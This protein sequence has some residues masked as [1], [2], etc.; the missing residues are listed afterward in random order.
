MADDWKDQLPLKVIN[1]LVY[2]LFLGSNISTIFVPTDI[3]THYKDTYITPSHGH[4]SFGLHFLIFPLKSY[5]QLDSGKRVII[6]GISWRFPLLGVFNAVFVNLWASNHH[7]LSFIFAILVSS[8]VSH[9]YY[10]VKKFHTPSNLYDELLVHLPFSLYHGWTTVLVVLTAFES[11]GA[12]ASKVA[13]SPATKAW[14][15]VALLFLESTGA[16]YAFSTPEGDFPAAIAIT[17]A[18]FA[19]F[20]HQHTPFIH[21][22]AL[23]FALLSLLWVIKGAYGLV[24]TWRRGGI[25][26]EDEERAPLTR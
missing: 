4:S 9:I 1:V 2:L 7:I 11:F 22:S 5:I 12:D 23:V 16:T 14:V 10:I 15:F 18:L 20:D 6:D 13:A 19:I 26:L 25:V 3:Y 8:T 21:W 24:T 17:W